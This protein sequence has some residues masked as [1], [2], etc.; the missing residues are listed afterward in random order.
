VLLKKTVIGHWFL[1]AVIG[2]SS[3]VI[4]SWLVPLFV[5]QGVN[6]WQRFHKTPHSRLPLLVVEF[7]Q[8]IH[9]QETNDQ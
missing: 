8:G 5:N 6:D 2:H 7:M 9:Q 3:L 4:G 1:K